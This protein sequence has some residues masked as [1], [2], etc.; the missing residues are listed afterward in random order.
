MI[1]A[2]H[3]PLIAYATDAV[4][5]VASHVLFYRMITYILLPLTIV[6]FSVSTGALLRRM[7]PR[8]YGVLTG[9]RGL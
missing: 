3:A 8:V 1:Y 4:F 5:S 7:L 2:V 9:G 6:A